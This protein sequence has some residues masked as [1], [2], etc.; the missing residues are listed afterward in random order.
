MM[1]RQLTRML[2]LSDQ[3]DGAAERRIVDDVVSARDHEAGILGEVALD[4]FPF[5]LQDEEA[6]DVDDFQVRSEPC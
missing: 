6:E 2:L 5:M 1:Q 3:R 4:V